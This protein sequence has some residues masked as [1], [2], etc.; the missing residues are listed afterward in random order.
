M[1]VDRT[2]AVEL[3]AD[4]IQLGSA[5]VR[6]RTELLDYRSLVCKLCL[7]PLE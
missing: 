7:C 5:L 6:E 4:G 3:L 1:P 2:L